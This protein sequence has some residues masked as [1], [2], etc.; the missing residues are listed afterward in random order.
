MSA[1]LDESADLDASFREAVS[2]IDRG[3]VAEL[4]RLVS[5]T[6]ARSAGRRTT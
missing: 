6:P 2:A 1:A 5:A 4:E 3:D